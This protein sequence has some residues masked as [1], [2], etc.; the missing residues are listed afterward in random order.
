LDPK[1]RVSSIIKAHDDIIY[2]CDFNKYTEKIVTASADKS[3]R[4]WDLRNL[5]IPYKQYP[6]HRHPVRKVMFSPHEGSI[7]ASGG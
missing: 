2:G 3:L 6:G 7:M 1:Q 4:L 5:K